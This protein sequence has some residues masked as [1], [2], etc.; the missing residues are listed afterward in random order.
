MDVALHWPWLVVLE[1]LWIG[2]VAAAILAEERSPVA[3][4]AWIFGL[5]LLPGIGLPIYLVFGPKRLGNKR[6]R[7]AHARALVETRSAP[8][9]LRM[10]GDQRARE[11]GEGLGEALAGLAVRCGEPPPLACSA[12]TVHTEGPVAYEAMLAAIEAA[13]HHVHLEYYIFQEGEIAGRF[14]DALVRKALAGVEVRLLVDGLGSRELERAY[15]EPLERAGGKVAVFNPIA[16]TRFRPRLVNFRSHRKILSCDG[17]VGFTGGMNV[18]DDHIGPCAYRDTNVRLEG[19]VVAALEVLFLEDWAF[20][21]GGAPEGEAYVHTPR[22]EGSL[23]AQVV[24]SGPDADAELAIHKQYFAAITMAQRRVLL[25]SAYF[26]PDEPFMLALTTA[27]R[28]GVDVRILVPMPSDHDFVDAAGRAFFPPLLRAGVRIFGYEG[29]VLHA[30]TLVVDDGY[31]AIGS[32][33]IDAR[34]F[35][36]NFELTVACFDRG[37]VDALADIFERDLTSA[38]E[39]TL[40]QLEEAP[41]RARIESK[42]AKLFA[43]IL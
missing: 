6:K 33:N 12:I 14:L 22:G 2:L 27:A 5:A 29:R 25:T 41:L 43:P 38:S 16:F 15:L 11:A 40:R 31:G 36:L 28:R 9:R 35:K 26:V 10:Q 4:L 13:T 32:A 39:I 19:D 18:C 21:T 17:R 42:I 7:R 37:V 24:A 8:A 3:T 23:R 20:A 30:K 1:L 34:S